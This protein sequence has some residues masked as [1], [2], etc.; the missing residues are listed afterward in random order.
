[1][2]ISW[3]ADDVAAGDAFLASLTD[4]GIALSGLLIADCAVASRDAVY[5]PYPSLT[6]EIEILVLCD[7]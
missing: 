1:M 3:S 4:S 6:A 2:T 7:E 5:L